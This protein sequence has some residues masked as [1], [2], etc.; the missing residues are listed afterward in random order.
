MPSA[1]K[2]RW[3]LQTADALLC[4]AAD[5]H[6]DHCWDH[7]LAASQGPDGSTGAASQANVTALYAVD[8]QT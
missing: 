8:L 6:I 3:G 5:K 7:C 1:T 4:A 2:S